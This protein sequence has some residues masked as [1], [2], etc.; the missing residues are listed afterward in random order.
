LQDENA[1]PMG[2]NKVIIF[3]QFTIFDLDLAPRIAEATVPDVSR[4]RGPTDRAAPLGGEMPTRRSVRLPPGL[5]AAIST[6]AYFHPI[7]EYFEASGLDKMRAVFEVLGLNG[8]L[9]GVPAAHFTDQPDQQGTVVE[10]CTAATTNGLNNPSAW[11]S[12]QTT[13]SGKQLCRLGWYVKLSTGSTLATAV[14]Q[15][16]VEILTI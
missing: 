1:I 14:M 3:Q 15:A 7:T 5:V 10:L 8:N 11:T 16:K 4:P 13:A 6:T 9:S 12:V 2:T